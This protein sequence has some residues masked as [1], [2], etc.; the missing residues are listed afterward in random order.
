MIRVIQFLRQSSSGAYSLERLYEDVRA[1]IPNDIYIETRFNRFPSKGILGRIFDMLSAALVQRNVNHVT[2]DVHYLTYFLRRKRTILTILDCVGLERSKG[3]KFWILWLL[4]YWL[5]EKC[6]TVI[7]VI[8]E[9]TRHQLIRNLNCDPDKIKVIYCTVS[10]EFC[11]YRKEFNNSCPTILHV[12]VGENKN[13][14]AHAAA[15]Q[16]LTCNFVIIGRLSDA[17]TQSLEKYKIHYEN[18]F[19]LSSAELVEQYKR[20]DILLF[21]STYEG[22]GLPIVEA[23]AIGRPVIT[24]NIWSMPEV[25]GDAACL[26]NPFDIDSIRYG[27]KRVIGD[28][29]Y[30]EELV[31]RG[32][33]NVERFSPEVISAQYAKLYREVYGNYQKYKRK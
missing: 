15:L 22:F 23:Q 32:L 3:V 9:S 11:F 30:R 29:E 17:Q 26:V 19:D 7:V 2:G 25:A 24:S 10:P 13:L 28:S 33:R 1:F 18:L 4:W 21:A 14:E 27:V 20:C 8:S 31:Q 5:P 16:G 6:C 12:G